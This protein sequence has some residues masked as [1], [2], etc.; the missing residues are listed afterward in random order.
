[1]PHTPKTVVVRLAVDLKTLQ[2]DPV[3]RGIDVVVSGHSHVPKIDTAGDVLYL[4]PG[5]AGRHRFRPSRLRRSTF[6]R[7]ACDSSFTIPASGHA[8][9][10]V[11]TLGVEIINSWGPDDAVIP[12]V[13]GAERL[14][15]G[16]SRAA[17]CPQRRAERI[18][19]SSG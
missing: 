13:A 4:N 3:A 9:S 17:Y 11:F 5:S 10:E 15:A 6:R 19:G 12:A 1:M 18:A 14:Q 16:I 2:I 7:T 8:D